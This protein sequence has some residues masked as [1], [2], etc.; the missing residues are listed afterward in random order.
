M[1]HSPSKVKRQR[2]EASRSATDGQATKAAKRQKKMV[3][4]EATDSALDCS[5]PPICIIPSSPGITDP[6]TT[7]IPFPVITQSPGITSPVSESSGAVCASDIPET[8]PQ[9]IARET[10]DEDDKQ[11]KLG[12]KN[13]QRKVGYSQSSAGKSKQSRY[14]YNQKK[15]KE[16][17]EGGKTRQTFGD[18]GHFLSPKGNADAGTKLLVFDE[19]PSTLEKSV[20]EHS[21]V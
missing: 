11:P 5:D 3:P 18:I 8:D 13:A 16:S 20:T 19:L 7:A 15:K 4:A 6:Q 12:R 21:L 9:F 1:P 14:Y 10:K 17:K 2:Q